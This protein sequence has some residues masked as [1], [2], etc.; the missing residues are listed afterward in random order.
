MKNVSQ[1]TFLY[2][3]F[4]AYGTAICAAESMY[5]DE[6]PLVAPLAPPLSWREHLSTP[7]DAPPSLPLPDTP[8]IE[9]VRGPVSGEE[10]GLQRKDEV[11]EPV[12]DLPAPATTPVID[13]DGRR[14]AGTSSGLYTSI[15]GKAFEAHPHYGTSEGPVSSQITGM[16]RD[17]RGTLWI[18]TAGGLSARDK[19]GRWTTF[20]GRDG[21]PVEALT[22][23][24]LD[25]Q[26]QLWIG[27]CRG[28]V[29]FRPYAEGRRWFYRQGKRY[30]PDDYVEALTVDGDGRVLVRTKE[31]WSGIESVGRTLHQKAA[32]LLDRYED[33]HR[34]LGMP[35]P[36]YYDDP[37]AMDFWTHG[38]QASDGL[39]TSYH[40]TSMAFAYSLTGDEQY[41]RLAKE[42]MEAL[43]RLQNITGV[44]GLVARSMAAIDE[45]SAPTLREQDNWHET[46]DG[47]YL[48]RDDVSSDQLTGHFFAFY[49]Y[50]EHIAKDDPAERARLEKQLRQVL[51]YILD[52]NYQIIDWD[53]KRTLWGWWN[54]EMVNAPAHYLESGLYSLMMLSFLKSAHHITGD[55]K[56]LE[57]Y[58]RLVNEHGYLTN[59][60]LQKKVFPD[61]LNHSDDQLSA[62]VFY[63]FLQMEEDPLVRD[64]LLRALR[65]HA[66]IEVPERN[67]LLTM[68]YAVFDPKDA[69]I[70]GALQTL[71]E[72]PLDRRDWRQENSHRSDVTLQRLKNVRRQ[73]LTLDVL[74]ADERMF[75]RWNADPYVADVGGTGSS[76]GAGVHW[77]L[78]YWMARYHG[79]LAGP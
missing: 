52:N 24:A 62:L 47:R 17:S 8:F 21:L 51:D 66:R 19:E 32:Y 79:I 35:S 61:E 4:L 42:G 10:L 1:T 37:V 74:P 46:K 70:A 30:L 27:T 23:L 64:V 73:V 14:W 6:P 55:E 76:E 34:R 63:P 54:P 53:G 13:Q 7:D 2:L 36:A 39:W 60:L 49:T 67:S 9:H 68:V 57:H 25:S 26:D 12:A 22:C 58:R 59:I 65:R 43:Y 16:A 29:H 28:L 56:Y 72:I 78:P 71:R 5:F 45:S 75:E 33:R 38:P 40:V 77:M 69:D 48:W 31:G 50:Y 44:P 20:R 15:D 3:M 41:R 11:N 18:A